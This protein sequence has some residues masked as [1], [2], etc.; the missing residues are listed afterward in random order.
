[1]V[2]VNPEYYMEQ[3]DER[4]GHLVEKLHK[5][6]ADLAKARTSRDKWRDIAEMAYESFHLQEW[7]LFLETYENESRNG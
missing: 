5:L 4:E 6:Q 7:Q 2:M 1:M 3:A